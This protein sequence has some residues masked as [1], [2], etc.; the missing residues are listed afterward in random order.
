M[1]GTVIIY[2]NE[3]DN[4]VAGD[5]DKVEEDEGKMKYLRIVQVRSCSSWPNIV[6]LGPQP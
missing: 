6:S 2:N 1:T 4:D 5:N 3:Y